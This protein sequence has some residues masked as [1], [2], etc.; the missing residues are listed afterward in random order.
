MRH[1]KKML[2]ALLLPALTLAAGS[3]L[4]QDPIGIE[5]VK[6]APGE[7]TMGCSAGDNDCN[8]DEKPAHRVKIT[9]AFEIGKHKRDD[10]A[11]ELKKYK[12]D[13]D[14]NKFGTVVP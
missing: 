8:A 11:N 13:F 2:C 4:A 12:K 6:V 14:L 9:K 1:H 10:I 3:T 5:F 7:F